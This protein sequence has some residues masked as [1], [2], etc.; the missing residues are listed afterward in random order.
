[1][2]K[3]DK[4]YGSFLSILILFTLLFGFNAYSQISETEKIKKRQKQIERE[5]KKTNKFLS[6]T[7]SKKKVSQ[8]QLNLLNKKINNR[9]HLIRNIDYQIALINKQIKENREK[10]SKLSSDL[11]E[12]KKQYARIIVYAYKNRNSYDKLMF[13]FAAE[14][15]NQSYRR[16]KYFQQYMKYRKRQADKLIKT[17][18]EIKEKTASLEKQKIEKASI[19]NN[20][21]SEKY[22]LDTDKKDKDIVLNKL[23]KKEKELRADLRKKQAAAKDFEHK[24]KIAIEEGSKK[25]GITKTKVNIKLS[26][27]FSNNRGRF[28]WPASP[29]GIISE[30]FGKHIDPTLGTTTENDGI[31]IQT[32][33]GA[34]ALAIFGGTVTQIMS[35]PTFN[36][37]VIV[38]HGVYYSVYAK[39]SNVSVK[40]GQKVKEKQKIGNIYTDTAEAKTIMHFQLRKGNT[41]LNPARWLRK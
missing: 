17:Q 6:E 33:A 14:D 30:S 20:R 27:T 35:I 2:K 37:V 39:L 10:V 23:S 3:K 31:N 19:L 11:V 15:I 16:I 1:M 9:V 7:K 26:N 25:P 29:K 41:K 4:K 36:N 34:Y 12:L 13:L 28:P 5:I 40:K 38:Q 32:S 24:L 18:A 22:K 8:N 21:R